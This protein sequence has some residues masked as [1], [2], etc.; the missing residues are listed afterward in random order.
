MV[1][2]VAADGD[3][4]AAVGGEAGRAAV[5]EPVAG[6]EHVV[7]GVAIDVLVGPV[8]SVDRQA[9]QDDVARAARDTD[10]RVG[11]AGPLDR[12]PAPIAVVDDVGAGRAR[13]PDVERRRE[14]IAPRDQAD[15]VSRN[16][17]RRHRRE[18]K[19]TRRRPPA[20]PGKPVGATYQVQTS[21]ALDELVAT[22]RPARLT[23]TSRRPLTP[24]SGASAIDT[25]ALPLILTPSAVEPGSLDVPA[26]ATA[27]SVENALAATTPAAND[28]RDPGR[29]SRQNALAGTSID[30]A[31]ERIEPPRNGQRG[32][33]R[34]TR[35]WPHRRMLRI[36][37]R[38][39]SLQA[40][41]LTVTTAPN[42]PSTC[43]L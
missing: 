34:S 3:V 4:V 33:W 26:D 13:T 14:P 17:P 16:G 21:L 35:G 15:D 12:R 27:G 7:G 30:R 20:F 31:P 23:R 9:A 19:R 36:P 32:P 10:H 39:R 8:R 18:W 22:D 37:G 6:D 1:D 2:E 40:P 29:A 24:A 43:A 41:K 42:P 11:A 5:Q 38:L 25:A 28:R